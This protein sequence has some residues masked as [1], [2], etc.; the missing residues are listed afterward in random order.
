MGSLQF[1]VREVMVLDGLGT[2][3]WVEAASNEASLNA[4]DAVELRCA[5]GSTLVSEVDGFPLINRGGGPVTE[6]AI[7]FRSEL[8]AHDAPVGTEIWSYP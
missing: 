8:D 5:D 6:V 2:V 4:G 3:V 1:V 7:S